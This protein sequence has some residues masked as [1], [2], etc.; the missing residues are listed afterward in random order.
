MQWAFFCALSR[1]SLKLTQ[2][3][4]TMGTRV[5]FSAGGDNVAGG[6]KVAIHLH[7]PKFKVVELNLHFQYA[8]MV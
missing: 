6:V 7:V 4:Y 5:C 2:L 8:Y 3:A 1:L